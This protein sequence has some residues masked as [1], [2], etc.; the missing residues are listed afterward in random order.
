MK[1]KRFNEFL[2][3]NAIFEKA[4]S[5]DEV[6]LNEPYSAVIKTVTKKP[7]KEYLKLILYNFKEKKVEGYIALEKFKTDSEF[8]INRSYAIDK[9]GP[10]MY[11]LALSVVSPAGIIPDRLIRPAAQKVWMYFDSQRPDV[12]KTTMKPKHIWFA[13]K[14]DI[15]IEHEN[16]K[17]PEILKLINK[18]YSV[19]APLKGTNELI[20]KGETLMAEYKVKPIDVIKKADD[21]FQTRY[22]AEM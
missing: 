16:L 3:E 14:Y 12:K 15:D 4:V 20:K 18:I 8:M 9:H 13:K 2:N 21:D 22:N 10:L 1:I 7:T 5:A 17:D 19:D 11:N 6:L